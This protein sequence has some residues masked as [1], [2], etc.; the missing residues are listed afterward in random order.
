MRP[1]FPHSRDFPLAA[2]KYTSDW[3]SKVENRPDHL[4]QD[5]KIY[6][7]MRK[8]AEFII[9]EMTMRQRLDR[10]YIKD[11]NGKKFLPLTT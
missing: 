8:F 9:P 7:H 3:Q 10:S 11:I 5:N 1:L 4:R 6:K 2:M